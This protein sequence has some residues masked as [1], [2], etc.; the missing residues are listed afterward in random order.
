MVNL[1]LAILSLAQVNWPNTYPY[2][3]SVQVEYH[4]S[5]DSL[6]LHWYVD[7]T[8]VRATVTRDQGPVYT[9][10]AV[11]FFCLLP[12]GKHYTNFEFNCLGYC[13]SDIQLGMYAH[14]RTH[15]SAEELAQ[16]HR[17]PSLGRDSLGVLPDTTHWELETTIPL[18]WLLPESAWDKRGHLRKN[19]TLRCNFYKCS[20]RSA[21]PHYLSYF[22][23]ATPKPNFHCPEYFQKI[24]LCQ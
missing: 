15:R 18:R 7:E 22:P 11:E 5:D 3:P 20:D 16:I 1:I 24:K 14:G 6:F 19:T 12:D 10:S 17:R 2:C 21:S 4:C 23:I 13:L 8:N 9:D